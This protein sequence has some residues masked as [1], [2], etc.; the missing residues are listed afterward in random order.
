MQ[1]KIIHLWKNHKIA[2]LVFF[3]LIVVTII[4]VVYFLINNKEGG[5]YIEEEIDPPSQEKIVVSNYN[6]VQPDPS[7]ILTPG[8]SVLYRNHSDSWV[9]A[10]VATIKFYAA[11]NNIDLSRISYVKD[12]YISETVYREG[13]EESF[14][15]VLNVDGQRLSIK[16]SQDNNVLNITVLKDN[17]Q[18]SH[19]TVSTTNRFIT[20]D[21]S[22]PSGQYD[23]GIISSKATDEAPPEGVFN[24]KLLQLIGDKNIT[25]FLACNSKNP[26]SLNECKVYKYNIYY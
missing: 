8:F 9:E 25:G 18:V 11:Q 21:G 4:I 5:L 19:S 14:D 2:L 16:I 15:V 23:G 22:I 1:Q 6:G 7:N 17:Q 10:I 3:Y 12:S 20:T 24:E 26:V 13:S